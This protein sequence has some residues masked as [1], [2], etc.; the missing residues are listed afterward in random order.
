MHT[1]L[2]VCPSVA[3]CRAVVL[4]PVSLLLLSIAS[5]SAVHAHLRPSTLKAAPTL[6]QLNVSDR[7]VFLRTD[8][9]TLSIAGSKTGTE[10]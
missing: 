5:A 9:E 10:T 4:L 8:A 1:D 2:F 7:T 6:A 3:P